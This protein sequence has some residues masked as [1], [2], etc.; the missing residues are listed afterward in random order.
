[1]KAEELLD[2]VKG[3]SSPGVLILDLNG[4]L[5]YSNPEALI[6]L[7]N[8]KK[9]PPEVL[10]LCKELKNSS[11]NNSSKSAADPSCAMILRKNESPCS[12][13]A[14]LIGA[15]E[16]GGPATHVMVLIEKVA[17]QHSPNLKKAKD[18]FR[19]TDREVEIVILV[20]QGLSNKDISARL[21][22]SEYTVKDHL[23]NTM[24]KM[25][26]TSRSEIIYILK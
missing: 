25:G 23:K 4:G 26:A 6:L 14:F 12:L 18:R 3:R 2:L 7:N 13:R 19:L 16:K 8:P 1:L 11:K 5:L 10:R 21:F 20:S 17:E 22:L 9:V 24:R 15:Q